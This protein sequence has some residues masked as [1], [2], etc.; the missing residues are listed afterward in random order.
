MPAVSIV[1]PVKDGGEDLAR[2]LAAI[3]AQALDHEPD[4]VVVD[5]GSTDG[6]VATAS[7]HGARVL[8]IPAAQFDHGATRNLGAE[9]ARGE[10]LVFI[11]QDAEPVG[12]GW[13]ADLIAPLEDER[14][15]GVYG[16]QVARPGAVPP[17][18]FFLDF[19]YGPEPR[20]QEL[21]GGRGHTVETTMFS[22]VNS[23]IRRS[24]WD[25]LRFADDLIMSEDQDW[26]RR[27]LDSGWRIVYEPRA[28]VRHSHAY[29]IGSAFRRF[30]DSGVSAE[31]AYLAGEAGA[32]RALRR[33]AAAYL[34][35]EL[36]WLVRGRR[37]RWIPYT[38]AYEASKLAGLVLGTRHRRL[39]L[40][41]KR[42]LS[43]MPSYW[44]RPG[45][46]R[47]GSER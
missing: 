16:R 19:V 22:N 36:R 15:A 11:S 5:S 28:V 8:E 3:R 27:A 7:E 35:A 34:S 44:N 21:T 45:G 30:F 6:S 40:G 14:V 1:I 47:P 25:A 26:S 29:S 42:R 31:R 41:L 12:S 43:A 4:L 32:S 46:R 10:V 20:V 17:E 2:C 24:A 18:A 33:T 37:A 23:A 39:P 13:L 9:A 38:L